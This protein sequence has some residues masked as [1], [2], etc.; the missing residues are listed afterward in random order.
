[1]LKNKQ[2]NNINLSIIMTTYNSS[3]TLV[4]CIESILNQNYRNFELIIVNNGANDNSD[5]IIKKY[6]EIDDRINYIYKTHGPITDGRNTGLFNARGTYI[7]FV[8]SDDYISPIMYDS[9]IPNMINENADIGICGFHKINNLS[10]ELYEEK[11]LEYKKISNDKAIKDFYNNKL[12][13]LLWNFIV[14]NDLYDGF[15]LPYLEYYDDHFVIPKILD[16]ANKIL[17]FK[18]KFYYYYINPLSITRKQKSFNEFHYSTKS[19]ESNNLFFKNSKYSNL[20]FSLYLSHIYNWYHKIMNVE[21]VDCN[22]VKKELFI[23]LENISK[24]S[25]MVSKISVI[26]KINL[27]RIKNKIQ[28]WEMNK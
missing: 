5:Q 13:I 7:T 15:I 16:S 11:T 21:I 23:K 20:V 9:I 26:K 8:D 12:T 10:F 22:N 2:K 18:N 28:K 1:M 4:R 17:V 6:I 27:L 19:Y 3:K 24:K 14:K 25:I